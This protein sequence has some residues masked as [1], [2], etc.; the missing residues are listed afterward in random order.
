MR[1]YAYSKGA[2]H[3]GTGAWIVYSYDCF[4]LMSV[5]K[6][7]GSEQECINAGAKPE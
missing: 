4:G 1:Y 5:T 2:G 7:F 3:Y 6:V